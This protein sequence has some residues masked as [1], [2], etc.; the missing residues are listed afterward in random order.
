M[1]PSDTTEPA[2]KKLLQAYQILDTDPEPYFDDIARLAGQICD[3]PIAAITFLDGERQWF[4]ATSGAP[5]TEAPVKHSFCTYTVA[6]E[7]GYFE[8]EDATKDDR[9]SDKP[10]VVDSPH[11]RSYAGAALRS[12]NGTPIGTICIFDMRPRAFS[13]EQCDALQ[14]LSKQV[15]AQL[16]LKLQVK[17]LEKQKRQLEA[18]N[19]QLDQF[20]YIIGHDLQAPIRHQTSFAKVILEDFSKE[21]PEEVISLL[22]EM[23][24]AGNRSKEIIDDINEYLHTVS[25]ANTTLERV[26][27]MEVLEEALVVSKARELCEVIIVSEIEADVLVAKIPM[28]HVLLNLIN[29]AVKYSDKDRCRL[30]LRIHEDTSCIYIDVGDDGPGIREADQKRIFQLFKRGTDNSGQPGRGIGL[31]I[32]A[33][34]LQVHDGSIDVKSELGKGAVFT[35]GMPKD[36][37]ELE[38]A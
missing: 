14:T 4:K 30:S 12:A 34:L 17:R 8:V 29:N 22:Q 24:K 26:P 36:S 11:V 37:V 2:R 27:A 25:K 16:L 19:S 7:F 9:F 23:V 32:A 15:M 3:A 5:I 35:V 20:A 33:K 18:L 28:R 13:E 6:S 38:E 10:H 31:A 1:N 21:L